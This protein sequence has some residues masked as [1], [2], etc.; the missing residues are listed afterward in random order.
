MA[1]RNGLASDFGLPNDWYKA[2]HLEIDDDAGT[3][4]IIYICVNEQHK[5]HFRALITALEN[6]GYRV[7]VYLPVRHTRE[8]ISRLGYGPLPRSQYWRKGERVTYDDIMCG[9]M[10][11]YLNYFQA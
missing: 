10:P 4:K 11:E 5:G 8:I 1:T 7:L 3:A 9:R 6:H 2:L